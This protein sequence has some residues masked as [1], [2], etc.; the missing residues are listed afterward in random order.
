MTACSWAD[1]VSVEHTLCGRWNAKGLIY[2]HVVVPFLPTTSWRGIISFV[3]HMHNIFISSMLN[4][5][6]ACVERHNWSKWSPAIS[7]DSMIRWP[8]ASVCT[9]A[10]RVASSLACV[11]S[12]ERC[13]PSA[14]YHAKNR[15]TINRR[16]SGRGGC[17]RREILAWALP[18]QDLAY[19]LRKNIVSIAIL[20][21]GNVRW[22]SIVL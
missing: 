13:E 20:K 3:I 11:S 7:F 18:Q 17:W 4:F 8:D 15:N 14:S 21:V 22:H 16:R 1:L 19:P 10:I 5:A 12:A 6:A 9:L 2:L